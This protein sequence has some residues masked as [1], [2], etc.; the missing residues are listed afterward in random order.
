MG[1]CS[2]IWSSRPGRTTATEVERAAADQQPSAEL[3][4]V[5]GSA[6]TVIGLCHRYD[7][8]HDAARAAFVRAA[9]AFRTAPDLV[10]E[11]GEYAAD[12]GIALAAAGDDPAEAE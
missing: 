1:R 11:R 7:G 9:A 2:P 6:A 8:D 10:D 3:A 4:A 12:L 5:V